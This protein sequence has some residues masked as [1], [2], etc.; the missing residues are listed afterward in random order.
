ML[1]VLM[2]PKAAPGGLCGA[3]GDISPQSGHLQPSYW[4]MLNEI[5]GER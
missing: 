1:T 2:S 3:A 5:G 4:L